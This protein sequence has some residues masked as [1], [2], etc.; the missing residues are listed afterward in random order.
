MARREDITRAGV[1]QLWPLSEV[2]G[3]QM[4]EAL[5]SSKGR[6]IGLR[7]LIQIARNPDEKD[8]GNWQRKRQKGN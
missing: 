5:I 2:A 7:S 6:E 3:E 8:E 4:D 1:S